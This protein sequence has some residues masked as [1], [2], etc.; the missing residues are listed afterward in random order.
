MQE[1][2][3][4]RQDDSDTVESSEPFTITRVASSI[5]QTYY[6]VSGPYLVQARASKSIGKP[7]LSQS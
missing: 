2:H 7:S 1:N 3:R 5:E 6:F 4:N